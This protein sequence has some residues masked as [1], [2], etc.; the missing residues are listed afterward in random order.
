MNT[1]ITAELSNAMQTTNDVL[2]LFFQT[3]MYNIVILFIIIL[4]FGFYFSRIRSFMSRHLKSFALFTLVSGMTLYFIG[5]NDEGCKGNTTALFLRSLL[6]SLEMFASHSDLIEVEHHCKN[7]HLYMFLFSITHFLAVFISAFF[8]IKL[9]GY[10][11]ASWFSA[12]TLLLKWNKYKFLSHFGFKQNKSHKKNLFVLWGVNDNSVTLAESI[13]K[14][15]GH[16]NAL[17]IFVITPNN[18]HSHEA[19]SRFSFI[20]FFHFSSD[21]VTNYIDRIEKIGAILM[22][23]DTMVKNNVLDGVNSVSDFYNKLNLKTLG[24]IIKHYAINDRNISFYFLSDDENNNIDAVSTFKKLNKITFDEHHGGYNF[25][26]FCH[27]RRNYFNSRILMGPGLEYKTY[28]I[29]TSL[30][31][32]REL[33]KDVHYQPVSLVDID[34][35]TGKVLTPFE[36]LIIGFGETGRDALRFMYE[37]STFIGKDGSEN[38]HHFYILDRNIEENR[39]TFFNSAPA[40]ADNKDIEW[41]QCSSARDSSFWANLKGVISRLNCIMICVD[42][43]EEAKHLVGAIYEYAYRYRDDMHNFRINVRIRNSSYKC[44]IEDFARS[45]NIE[46]II[47]TF[48]STDSIFDYENLSTELQEKEAKHFYYRYKSLTNEGESNNDVKNYIDSLLKKDDTSM[49]EQSKYESL[50]YYRRYYRETVIAVDRD[51]SEFLEAMVKRSSTEDNIE[52]NYQE[53]QDISNA[54][55]IQ[56]KC[57]LAGLYDIDNKE[58]RDARISSLSMLADTPWDVIA[59]RAAKDKDCELIATLDGVEHLRWNA[60]MELMGFVY[61]ARPDMPKDVNG[62]FEMYQW[63]QN[64]KASSLRHRTHHCIMSYADLCKNTSFNYSI[65]YDQSVVKLSLLMFN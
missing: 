28:L 63:K 36:C 12:N 6:S 57:A 50:W 1:D 33:K 11:L 53:A 44:Q 37:F 40:L 14:K 32:I 3:W 61:G 24:T 62:K 25:H 10:R 5:F 49:D 51:N 55:H 20:H 42:T 59:A 19:V 52:V 43:D 22:N 34:H 29:D 7:D 54:W 60:K 31:S 17:I 26:L 39:N 46:N 16:D 2:H 9:F 48:G 4:A 35:T 18:S 27:A 45:N 15:Y 56:T 41:W 64:I 23:A 8:I 21:S 38:M 30:L 65:A 58:E 47:H 13:I